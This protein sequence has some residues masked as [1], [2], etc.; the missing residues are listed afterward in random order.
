VSIHIITYAHAHS[1]HA[2][3]YLRYVHAYPA[4]ASRVLENMKGK[5]FAHK[6]MWNE[7]HISGS[8]HTPL[9]YHYKKP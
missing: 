8:H 9:F 2:Y 4:H 5:I 3:A 7:S 1:N 6:F